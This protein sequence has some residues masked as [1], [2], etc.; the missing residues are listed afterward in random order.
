MAA[1][2]TEVAEERPSSATSATSV[3]HWSTTIIFRESSR[4]NSLMALRAS[5]AHVCISQAELHHATQAAELHHGTPVGIV[6]SMM[7]LGADKN[8]PHPHGDVHTRVVDQH[9][10]V[11]TVDRVAK[12]NAF[13]PRIT[14]GLGAALTRLDDDPELFVGVLSFAGA[15]TTAGLEMPLF[16]T[17]EARAEAARAKAEQTA[18]PVDPFGL[19]RRLRKPLVTAVQGITFTIGIEIALAGDIVIAASDARFCQ[20]E[21]KRGLAHWVVRP[22]ATCNGQAGGTRCIT[23]FV[24]TNS[25]PTRRIALDCHSLNG[26]PPCSRDVEVNTITSSAGVRS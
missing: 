1:L 13:T 11:I 16:F 8:E 4:L 2:Q 22:C 5:A 26:A 25:R 3:R 12:K 23:C 9:V 7:E 20:L 19:G 18:E 14:M 17:P 6:H 21:P 24:P 15:H 10:L